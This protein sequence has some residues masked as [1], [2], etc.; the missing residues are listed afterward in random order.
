MTTQETTENANG[1]NGGQLVVNVIAVSALFVAVVFNLVLLSPEVRGGIFFFNDT[2]LHMLL[3][4]MAV[5]AITKGQNVTDPWQGTMN[6]GTPVFH[7]YQHLP[8]VAVALVHVLTF[9]AIPVVTL[10]KWASYLLLSAFPLSIY[11]SLRRFGFS[12]LTAAMGGIVSPLV[13]SLDAADL[14]ELYGG[15]DYDSYTTRG[16]GLFTQLWAMVLLPPALALGYR[17]L[18][19]GQGYFWATLLLASTFMSHLMFGYIAFI[20]LGGL[21]FIQL[22][23]LDHPRSIP[24]VMWVQWRRLMIL[25]LLVA[26][27]T[28]YFLIPFF[29]DRQYFNIRFFLEPVLRD[30]LGYSAVLEGLFK[31]SLFDFERLP[32]ITILVL[33][34]FVLCVVRW[35]E[36][37]YLIPAAIFLLWLLLYFGRSTWG[38]LIDVLPM[39]RYIQ[40]HRFIAGVHLGGILLAAIALAAAW[41]WAISRTQLWYLVPV[42]ALT[43]LFLLPVYFERRS[44]LSDNAFVVEETREALAAEDGNLSGLFERLDQLPPGRIYAGQWGSG[45]WGEQYR[46]GFAHMFALLYTEGVDM[47]GATYHRY[48]LSSEVVQNFDETA[49]EQYNLFNVRY[50]VAPEK[51]KFPAFVKPLQKFGRHN[52][53]EVETSGY[54]DLVGSDLV[55]EGDRTDFYPAAS[56]WIA[57]DLPV[58]K[59]HPAISLGGSSLAGPPLPLSEA[60]SLIPLGI[61]SG[62]SSVGPSRGIV[63][64]EDVGR[65]FFVAKVDVARESMLLLKTNYHPN[66]RV[67]VDGVTVDKVML[68]PGFLGVQLTRGEHE[69][70]FEYQPRR[71]RTVLLGLGLLTLLLIPVGERR[72]PA[73]S[74][75]IAHVIPASPIGSL[76]WPKRTESRQSRRRR[77]RR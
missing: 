34:G 31:G 13:A 2:V 5:E 44:Y 16:W 63:L 42:L 45:N 52:L 43:L 32:S 3:I 11:W 41:R 1:G 30:S 18:R 74:S 39:S 21:T 14:V 53:Y 67:T 73:V 62:P 68:M 77:R 10:V 66:W 65:D 54:F 33:A 55:F 38:P 7:Y 47:V 28:S 64:S 75:W 70:R 56:T 12:K 69:V 51:Q 20:T 4:D 49:W 46:V 57:S 22:S 61:P 23:R 26:V 59:Q 76:K 60:P 25:V 9:E 24:A 35:R 29:L 48:S 15:L 8:H 58:A 50:V 37:R 72:A 17:V 36:E 27:V 71:L 19:D 40:M 6:M